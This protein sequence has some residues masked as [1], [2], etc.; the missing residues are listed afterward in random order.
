MATSQW[1]LHRCLHNSIRQMIS[2]FLGR[3]CIIQQNQLL[4]LTRIFCSL[5]F[6]LSYGSILDIGID[7]CSIMASHRALVNRNFLGR[8]NTYVLDG[9]LKCF[10]CHQQNMSKMNWRAGCILKRILRLFSW[11]S[12]GIVRGT[13]Q[14]SSTLHCIQ[15]RCVLDVRQRRQSLLVC[16]LKGRAVL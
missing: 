8:N 13:G 15:G 14:R 10:I 7:F 3:Y 16:I 11:A 6:C 2:S 1:V 4:L 5:L 9:P 12:H